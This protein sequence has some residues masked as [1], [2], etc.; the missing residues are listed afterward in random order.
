[1]VCFLRIQS[2]FR[3]HV[4]DRA[5]HT[6]GAGQVR[7]PCPINVIAGGPLNSCKPHVQD[8]NDTFMIH[9]QIAGFDITMN[10]AEFVSVIEPLRD[11]TDDIHGIFDAERS[12]SLHEVCQVVALNKLHHQIVVPVVDSGVVRR[13]NILVVELC[14]RFNFP[15][16]S[17]LEIFRFCQ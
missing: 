6:S 8:T 5:Q 9:Q 7:I 16:E 4:V 11:L 10:D 2:L 3:S 1:M 17:L 13:D 15:F 14:C 12:L